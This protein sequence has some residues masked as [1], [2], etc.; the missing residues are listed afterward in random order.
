[1]QSVVVTATGELNTLNIDIA[2]LVRATNTAANLVY[3]FF[4]QEGGSR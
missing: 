3:P 2:Y 1:V 4:L